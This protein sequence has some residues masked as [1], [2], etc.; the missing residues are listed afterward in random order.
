VG[1]TPDAVA[2]TCDDTSLTYRELEARSNQLSGYLRTL[3][4]GSDTTVGVCVEKSLDV[5]V[6]LLAILKAGG[7]YVLIDPSLAQDLLAHILKDTK[8]SAILVN[9]GTVSHLPETSAMI[10]RLDEEGTVSKN[11]GD[12]MPS[13]LVNTEHLA[14]VVYRASAER[15]R[16]GVELSHR[17]IVNTLLSMKN[18][19]KLGPQDRVL[20]HSPLSSHV[21]VFELWLPLTTGARIVVAPGLTVLEPDGLAKV[22]EEQSITMMQATPSA[23][24]LLLDSGWKGSSRIKALCRGEAL[25]PDLATRLSD[26]CAE[27]WNVYGTVETAFVAL[28]GQIHAG[29]QVALGHPILDTRVALVDAQFTPVPVGVPGEVLI[30]SVGLAS[31]YRN[32]PLLVDETFTI[33]SIGGQNPFKYYCTGD[34]ARYRPNG[35]IE[36]VGRRD[37]QFEIHGCFVEPSEIERVLRR[38]TAVRDVV[39]SFRQDIGHTP[40]LVAYLNADTKE[41][42]KDVV[43]ELGRLVHSALPEYMR[44]TKFVVLE[45]MPREADGRI[46]RCA[47]PIPEEET[48]NFED[49]VAPRNKVEQVLS[50]I[51]QELLEVEKVS[52]KDSFFDLGGKSLLAVRLFVRIEQELGRKLPLATLFRAPTLEQIARLLNSDDR[53]ESKWPSLVPIQA[54]GTKPPLFLV[55]GAG[56]NVLLYRALA[57][58][59][60]PDYPVYGL[61]S[62]GLDGES[63]PLRTIEAMADHYMRE[64][65]EVQ[66]YGPYL[67]GGYCLGGTVAYEMAQR[68]LAGGERVYGVVMLDTYNFSL[69]LK[70]SF[71]SFLMQKLRFHWGSLVGLRPGAMWR[72]LKAKKGSA[73]DGGWAGLRTEMP[74]STLEDGVARAESGVEAS[75]QEINDHAADI[76]DPK[77]Y[78]GVLTL[79]KPHINY[80]FYPD[81]KMGWGDLAL[82]GL[83][84]VELPLNPHAM[85][86]EPYVETL[87]RELKARLDLLT[88]PT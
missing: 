80:K 19:S 69:A 72:Y 16:G 49:H 65:R 45:E 57:N 20:W 59:L 38:H 13:S 27:V 29:T 14:T 39:V 18:V 56:G 8:M 37:R 3:G 55:H 21:E 4:V 23:W 60:A 66:P 7:A 68:L 67:L 61:Q 75:V 87:A 33:R 43:K 47:L 85:L 12:T 79:V 36:F 86:V 25:L 26:V 40:A 28:A 81:P 11:R 42:T 76:Y 63:E 71:A 77:P 78:S 15:N 34:I 82:G 35:D 31:G 88:R 2:L 10:V 74:G 32:L 83:D 46:D 53:L 73:A 84:I 44:P 17:A 6:A 22:V 1:R 62:Q 24:R 5:P 52:V 54:K 64:I 9:S 51:W 30:S 48:A 50:V 70:A 41:G 58:R